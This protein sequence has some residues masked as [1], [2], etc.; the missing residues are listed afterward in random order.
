MS[1]DWSGTFLTR[2]RRSEGTDNP[3]PDSGPIA[4]GG[5]QQVVHVVGVRTFAL[6][7]LKQERTERSCLWD[8]G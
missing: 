6:E 5:E 2:A 3:L 7:H 1:S 8:L 4:F